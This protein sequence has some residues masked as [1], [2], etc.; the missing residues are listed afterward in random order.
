MAFRLR[1]TCGTWGL[2]SLHSFTS[3]TDRQFPVAGL[4][5]DGKGNAY[6]MTPEGGDSTCT[7]FG[8]PGCGVVYEITGF[9]PRE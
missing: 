5:L 6:G 7:T 8:Q 1:G 2:S 3:G 9:A 4:I